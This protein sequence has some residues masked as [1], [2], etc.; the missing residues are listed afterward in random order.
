MYLSTCDQH[1]GGVFSPCGECARVRATF[2]AAQRRRRSGLIG[3]HGERCVCVEPQR[4]MA[5]GVEVKPDDERGSIGRCFVEVATDDG[6]PHFV[7]VLV[8]EGERAAVVVEA[9]G[10]R[11]DLS[12]RVGS[13]SNTRHRCAM[14]AGGQP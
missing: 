9:S 2:E 10:H 8:R 14:R 4:D 7:S 1:H 13:V 6:S 12:V 5:A 11:G 3:G